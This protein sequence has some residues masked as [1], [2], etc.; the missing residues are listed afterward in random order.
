MI[1]ALVGTT[2]VA[3][4]VLSEHFAAPHRSYRRDKGRPDL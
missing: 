2:V 4:I 1:G 3:F